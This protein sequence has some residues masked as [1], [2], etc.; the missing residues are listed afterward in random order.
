GAGVNPLNS[1]QLKDV[2]INIDITPVRVTL[3]G[4]I[5]IDLTLE[6]STRGPDVNIAGTNYPSFGSRKVGTR[7]RLRDGESNLMAGLLREDERKSLS[8]MPGAIHVPVL[9]Q[10]FSNNDE[11][12]AQTDIVMLLTPHIVRA[13]E[14]KESDLR[15]VFIGSQQNLGL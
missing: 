11:Q 9:K 2:G 10:L 12:I 13:P 6:S 14:I 3:E 15:P 8:G 4:D 1:F 7:L 5:V